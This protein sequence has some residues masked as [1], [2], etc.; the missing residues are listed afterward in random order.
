MLDADAFGTLLEPLYGAVLDPTCLDDFNRQ[1]AR[2]TRSHISGVLIHDV[3]GGQAAAHRVHG[4]DPAQ[5][6]AMLDDHDLRDDPWITH[7]VPMLSTGRVLD[8]DLTI[9]RRIAT[10][11]DFYQAYYRRL[12]IVQQMACVGLYDGASSVT[13]SICHDDPARSYGQAE[14]DLL[15]RLAPH[16]VNAYA[17]MRRIGQLE[18]RAASL[19]AVLDASPV[20][21]FTLSRRLR[22]LRANA[23]AECLLAE[24]VLLRKEGTLAAPGPA[25]PQLAALLQRALGGRSR[26]VQGDIERLLLRDG[27][28]QP[29][30]ILTAHPLAAVENPGDAALLVFVREA[31]HASDSVGNALRDLFGLTAAEARLALALHRHADLSLAAQACAITPAT[32]QTRLKVIFG[33]TGERGQPALVR[34]VATLAACTA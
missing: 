17:M 18:R 13:F 23:S 19:Q 31:G 29:T 8:S 12:G 2:V 30:R 28:D 22:L 24:G 3:M 33:K 9:P 16:W 1:L 15:N 25:A 4:V 26:L 20:A 6:A 27:V 7:A 5:L 21:M 32:A 14:T 34:L 10:Q 11:H